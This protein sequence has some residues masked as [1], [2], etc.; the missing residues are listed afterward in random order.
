MLAIRSADAG[1]CCESLTRRAGRISFREGH[2][3]AAV[4]TRKPKAHRKSRRVMAYEPS[5][6]DMSQKSQRA[7]FFETVKKCEPAVLESLSQESMMMLR[8]ARLD[9]PNIDPRTLNNIWVLL[10]SEHWHL[11]RSYGA[12]FLWFRRKLWEWGERWKLNEE[13]C[14]KAA[15]LTLIDWAHDPEVAA[16]RSWTLMIHAGGY[17]ARPIP[18]EDTFSFKSSGWELTRHRTRKKYEQ[19]IRVEFEKALKAY[20]DGIEGVALDYGYVKIPA[21]KHPR[22][23]HQRTEWLVRYRVQGWKVSEINAHYYKSDNR[24][25]I[26][27]GI[28]EAAAT[29]GFPTYDFKGG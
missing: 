21:S 20:C 16:E 23:P 8:Q 19:F 11:T 1:T 24:N 3:E 10:A 6:S 12:P 4:S 27:K 25:T 15:F 9:D 29:L 26:R 5:R 2:R 18:G 14:L 13:W 17:V 7:L 28:N 22:K